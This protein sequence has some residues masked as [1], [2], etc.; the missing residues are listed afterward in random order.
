[1]ENI[2]LGANISETITPDS[3]MDNST[4]AVNALRIFYGF[5]AICGNSLIITCVFKY[6]VLRNPTNLVIANLSAA[7]LLNGFNMVAVSV[8]NLTFCTG[9]SAT[10]YPI[11]SVKQGF[12][13]LGFLMNNLAIFYI[14]L[15]RFICIKLALRYNSIIT[16]SRVMFT[17]VLT[18]ICGAVFTFSIA[19]LDFVERPVI[20][21]C[22][23]GVIGL[24][25]LVCTSTLSLLL[26]KNRNKLLH[27]H[28]LWMEAQ[29][30]L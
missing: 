22:I 18:W 13:Q 20:L 21:Y 29:L 9:L 14:A 26:L 11:K 27:C 3:K 8:M 12:T 6:R 23:Y 10:H 16:F 28:R 17:C 19:G 5:T 25:T 15:E 4:I 1:M 24:G 7:D 2:T 30:K